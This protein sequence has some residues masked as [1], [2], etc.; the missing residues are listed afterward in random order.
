M[1][2]RIFLP[3]SDDIRFTSKLIQIRKKG[4]IGFA[5]G[6]CPGNDHGSVAG[7]GQKGC[8][9]D[10]TVIVAAI[11]GYAS[12]KPLLSMDQKAIRKLGHIGPQG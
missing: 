9:H 7:G 4:G 5:D 2:I 3:Y 11:Y 1:E 10:D 12:R 8:S 6:F